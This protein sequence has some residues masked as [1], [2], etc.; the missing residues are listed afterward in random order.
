MKRKRSFMFLLA[1]AFLNVKAQ[2]WTDEEEHPVN[3]FL[4]EAALLNIQPNNS[5]IVFE[6]VPPASAGDP[7]EV[8]IN[9]KEGNTKWLNYTNALD[10]FRKGRNIFV[11]IT[12]GKIPSGLELMIIASDFTGKG[13]GQHGKSVGKVKVTYAP[14]LLISNI[15]GCYTGV[16]SSNGHQI[17]YYAI[18][19]DAALLN[20]KEEDTIEI[21][22]TITDN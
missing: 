15:K 7:P 13:L 9:S 17:T 10:D 19:T 2:E 21:S 8:I 11:E 4:S 18:I 14:V 5:D 6:M 1:L 12:D 20:P 3:V 22:Y 16:G